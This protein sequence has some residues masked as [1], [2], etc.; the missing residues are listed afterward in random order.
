MALGWAGSGSAE[1][2][3]LPKCLADLNTC[4]AALGKAQKF[5][6]TGQTT[7]WDST[8]NVIPC[9]GTGQD[10]DIRAGATLRYKDNG[11]GTIIDK[12]TGLQWEKKSADGD[13]LHDKD[14][15]YTWDQ[16]FTFVAE[17]NTARFARHH[18]WRV[19][20]VKE[21]QSIVNYQKVSPAVSSAFNTNCVAGFDALTGSC[22]AADGYW[23]STTYVGSPALFAWDMDF[24][25]VYVYPISDKRAKL[26]VRAVR[27][28][29]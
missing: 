13:P 27:G 29:L 7:C 21:L 16:A 15:G 17:L 22:T 19:P 2:G 18:D 9:A 4:N 3:G 10:G 14:I 11:D 12:N 23:S 26:H 6:A 24:T 8:G 5:P 25:G 28:G 1:P 20:N